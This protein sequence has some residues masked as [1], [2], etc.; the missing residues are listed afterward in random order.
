ME[1]TWREV[2]RKG[3]RGW[4]GA[5]ET[6]SAKRTLYHNVLLQGLTLS[7]QQCNRRQEAEQR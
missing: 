3:R 4:W 7:C 1:E 5:V 2:G 6:T